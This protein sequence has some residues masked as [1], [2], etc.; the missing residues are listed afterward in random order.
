MFVPVFV[1]LTLV[2]VFATPKYNP[3]LCTKSPAEIEFRAALDKEEDSAKRMQLA[4]A[5]VTRHLEDVPLGRLAG[6]VIRRANKENTWSRVFFKKLADE[7]PE[8]IAAQYYYAR[9]ADDTTVWSEKARWVLAKDSTN[10]WGWLMFM[11][12]EW[13]RGAPDLDLVYQRVTR[14]IQLDPSRPEGYMFLGQ[15]YEEK[16]LWMDAFEAYR[17][18]LVCDP[19]SKILQRGVEEMETKLEAERG[20]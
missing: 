1:F 7:H 18:G 5:Y 9:A 16:A 4:E 11:A 14:A 2:S 8:S 10:Y 17:A 19:E 20:K 6:D 3:S 12:A 13:H 15:Y